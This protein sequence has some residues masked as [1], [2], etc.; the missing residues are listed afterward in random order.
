MKPILSLALAAALILP[1]LPGPARALPT[2][3]ASLLAQADVPPA[4]VP[5]SG[6]LRRASWPRA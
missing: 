5:G 6:P 3:G 2:A 1:A 4:P